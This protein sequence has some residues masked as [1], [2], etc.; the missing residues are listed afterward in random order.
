VDQVVADK[1]LNFCLQN[2]LFNGHEF[3]QVLQ[4]ILLENLPPTPQN[5]IK[6]FDKDHQ[7]KASQSPQTSNIEDYEDIINQQ[8]NTNDK[9]RT[10]QKSL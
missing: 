4:V 3:D 1:T 8:I 5:P 9:N 10:D 2:Q 7:E 6:L